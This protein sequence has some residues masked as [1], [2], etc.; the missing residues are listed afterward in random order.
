MS[1][2]IETVIRDYLFT[3]EMVENKKLNTV[4]S[5]RK[6]LAQFRRYLSDEE[7]S[8]EIGKI[9]S[10]QLRG[11]LLFLQKNKVVRRSI[12][13]KLSI[14]RG[15]FK[16]ALKNKLITV[17]PMEQISSFEFEAEEPDILSLE[18]V[19]RLR[20]VISESNVH[21][22]RDRLIVELLYSSGI[23]ATEMLLTSEN[24]FSPEKRELRVYNGKT[25]RIV[26]FSQKAKEYYLR[27][28]EAKKEHFR[29]KYNKNIVFVNG[30]GTKLSDRSL[31]RLIDRY[32]ARAGFTREISPYSFRHTFA[33]H[34]LT[35]GMSLLYLKELMGH[36]TIESTLPYET[37]MIRKGLKK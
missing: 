31:R 20:A 1:E 15:F 17:N 30:S 26:F 36:V 27:Y 5:M 8:G 35:H 13:R 6:D 18:E 10:L 9:T 2:R 32:A 12:N 33:L 11:F 4:K 7:K 19:N 29:E 28:I 24:M 34:M 16:F 22:L 3:A 21:G 23:T 37:L 25:D 14:L